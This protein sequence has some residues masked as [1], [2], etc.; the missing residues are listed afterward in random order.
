MR[1]MNAGIIGCGAMG[2]RHLK[3]Y[4]EI[5]GIEVKAMCD[6]NQEALDKV[7]TDNPNIN[8][9]TDMKEMLEKENLDIVSVVTLGP[10]HA[11]I[12]IELAKAK[13]PNIFCEKPIATSARECHDMIEACKTNNSKLAINHVKRYMPAYIKAKELIEQNKIGTISSI[14]TSQG[15]G[16]LGCMGTH[17]ID[18]FNFLFNK[19][20]VSVS[21]VIDSSY[22]GDHKG[23][24][25]FDPGGFGTI[26]YGDGQKAILDVT[27]NLGTPGFVLVNGSVGRLV[28]DEKKGIKLVSR[29]DEDFEKRLGEYNLPLEK[30]EYFET[31]KIAVEDIT[32]DSIKNFLTGNNYCTAEQGT[33]AVEVILGIH[34]ADKTNTQIKLPLEGENINFEVKI[35]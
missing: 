13:V 1:P 29:N 10:S 27:E 12:V 9:Y 26:N 16:R 35:T 8:T 20:P 6:L 15:G 24:D 5:E 22:K 11:N 17:I 32:R 3:A 25:V 23:R 28:I 14:Y 33:E 34:L 19:S 2:L 18:L 21:G 30:E 4:N 7:K 31:G